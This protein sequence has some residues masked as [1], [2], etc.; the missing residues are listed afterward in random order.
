MYNRR[1]YIKV[2]QELVAEKDMIFIAGPRQAGKTT[3]SGLIAHSFS[4]NYYF[5]WDIAEHRTRFLRIY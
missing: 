4:N 2:W 5:N 1:F 3:L